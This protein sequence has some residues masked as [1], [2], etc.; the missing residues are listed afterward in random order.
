MPALDSVL[1]QALDRTINAEVE[2]SRSL[3]LHGPRGS[4]KSWW[5]D[6][7][8]RRSQAAGM[9]VVRVDVTA[10][11]ADRSGAGLAALGDAGLAGVPDVAATRTVRLATLD[12]L[13]AVARDRPLCLL[14]D[15]VQGMDALSR[16]AIEFALDHAVAEPIVTIATAPIAGSLRTS[17]QVAIAPLSRADIVRLLA[18][19]GVV[20]RVAAQCAEIA[21]GNPGV[22]VAIVDG[23]GDDQRRGR[24]PIPDIPRLAGSVAAAMNQ[25][26]RHLGDDL[27][28][29]L[30]VAAADDDGDIDSVR[31][32]LVQLGEPLA[33]LERAEGLGL[34]TVTD[35]RL[36]F[37]DQWTRLVAYHL[38]APSSRRAAHRALA[39]CYGDAHQARARVR[40]I[41]GAA[42]G[43]DDSVAEALAL[44][45]ADSRAAAVH[46]RRRRAGS[47]GR[48][49]WP[50]RV[51]AAGGT[52]PTPWRPGP[53]PGC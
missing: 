16:D 37:P 31:Q 38:V 29:A 8:R 28:R 33:A 44:V 1:D 32:A 6:A 34:I 50:A 17:D 41:V 9:S 2:G 42:E 25:R 7:A 35:G 48:R 27:C 24:A 23:L 20:N 14:L 53:T 47:S 19:R 52:R 39:S 22:A 46:W 43:C 18:E 40:H 15:N 26:L 45:A 10:S 21:R 12:A 36:T 49:R 11:M 13:T 3:L 30:A 5:L 4:G 51:G